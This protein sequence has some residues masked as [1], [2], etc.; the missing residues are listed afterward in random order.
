MGQ[1]SNTG[2]NITKSSAA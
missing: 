2:W 1:G